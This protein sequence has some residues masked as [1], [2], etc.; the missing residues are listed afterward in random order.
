MTADDLSPMLPQ[1]AA[2]N[3]PMISGR[4]TKIIVDARGAYL[5]GNLA[6]LAEQLNETQQ[7][8]FRLA[9]IRLAV[10]YAERTFQLLAADAEEHHY[11]AQAKEW[12][13]HPTP[14]PDGSLLN[15]LLQ[16][17][18]VF[19]DGLWRENRLRGYSSESPA[20]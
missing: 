12:L 16:Y 5:A 4:G 7:Q 19:D 8:V 18:I 2:D 3:T 13:Q 9:L 17:G 11:I 10:G 1:L 14:E 6:A 15:L 20:G